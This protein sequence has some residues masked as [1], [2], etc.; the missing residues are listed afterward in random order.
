MSN[1]NTLRE[2]KNKLVYDAQA[3]LAKDGVSREDRASARKMIEDSQLIH[4]RI[5]VEERAAA[6]EAEQRHSSRPP[7]GPIAEDADQID[8]VVDEKRSRLE[9]R[10]F[11]NYITGKL[12]PEDREYLKYEQRDMT[13]GGAAGVLVPVG[14]DPLLHT[15]TKATGEIL[16]GV[17]T[18]NTDSG[19]GIKVGTADPTAVRFTLN[20]ENTAATETD[21]SV[22]G[23]TSNVDTLTLMTK[24]SNQLIQDSAFSIEQFLSETINT[25]WVNTASEAIIAGNASNF[26]SLA[27]ATPVGYTAPTGGAS[28][29]SY[30][31][32]I[33]FYAKLDP[34][35]L[36]GAALWMNSR[37]WASLLDIKDSQNRPIL[38][39]DFQGNPFKSFLG[40]PIR[41][42]QKIDDLGASKSPILLGDAY[43]SYTYRQAGPLVVRKSVDRYLEYNATAFFAVQRAGG[44]STIQTS[45]P[46]MIRLVMSAT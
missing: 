35:Y 27:T 28:T 21:P 34:S 1:L 14:F 23:F 42:A 31:T 9:M 25:A 36:A 4:E 10:A 33:N 38:T 43:K 19:E 17:R 39:T 30:D 8:G 37:T 3:I 41:I 11:A 40:L 5:D 24:V 26:Q 6:I 20:P 18:W 22:G 12:K 46:S 45:S 7:R 15:A 44:Y 2:Q 29:I 13:V 16:S 32:L